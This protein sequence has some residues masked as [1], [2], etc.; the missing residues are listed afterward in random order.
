MGIWVSEIHHLRR[1]RDGRPLHNRHSRAGRPLHNRHSR[2]GGNPI[3]RPSNPP[4]SPRKETFAQPCHSRAGGNPSPRPRTH[5]RS[6]ERRPLHNR[7]IPAQAG[8]HPPALEP[9]VVPAKGDLC[10]AV[11]PAAGDLCTHRHSRAGGNPIPRPSNPPSFPRK[12][13]FAQPSFPRR[14]EP[15]PRPSNPPS[16]PRKETFAQPSSRAGG[17]PGWPGWVPVVTGTTTRRFTLIPTLFRPRRGR[18]LGSPRVPAPLLRH[19]PQDRRRPGDPAHPVHKFVQAYDEVAAAFHGEDDHDVRAWI[20]GEV[21]DSY[22][23]TVMPPYMCGQGVGS[24][25]RGNDGFTAHS[26]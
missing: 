8:T 2:A 16:F 19:R 21:P 24:R 26:K 12:E 23:V 11:I 17:N 22:Q 1:S 13:T 5:R 18:R 4:S 25:L 10:T 3:P 6:R 15:I 9:T 14:R 7:V 20:S